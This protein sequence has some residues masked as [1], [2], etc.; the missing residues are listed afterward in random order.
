M[1]SSSHTRIKL[2]GRF[3]IPNGRPRTF[4]CQPDIKISSLKQCFF[5]SYVFPFVYYFLFLTF[6]ILL[7]FFKNNFFFYLSD[8]YIYLWYFWLN[9]KKKK[10]MQFPVVL[11]G[12]WRTL[13]SS[14]YIRWRVL[15]FYFF[16]PKYLTTVNGL[17]HDRILNWSY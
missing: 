13:L 17:E 7:H 14:Q 15:L 6:V 2:F 4:T 10:I 5:Y 12:A 8:K 3:R 16:F 11:C 9:K 1:S